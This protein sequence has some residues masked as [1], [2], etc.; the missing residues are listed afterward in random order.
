MMAVSSETR[1]VLRTSSAFAVFAV[2]AGVRRYPSDEGLCRRPT[3]E[4]NLFRKSDT[5]EKQ[6]VVGLEDGSLLMQVCSVC[7]ALLLSMMRRSMKA[8]LLCPKTLPRQVFLVAG[9][10]T[11]SFFHQFSKVLTALKRRLDTCCM[12][13]A[14]CSRAATQGG[15]TEELRVQPLLVWPGAP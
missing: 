2:D 8:S 14:I 10:G 3:L 13:L 1:R 4:R 11:H 9:S 5:R 12:S 6:G 7:E 15:D